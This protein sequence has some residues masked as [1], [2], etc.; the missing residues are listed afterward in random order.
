MRVRAETSYD[1][2]NPEHR[3]LLKSLWAASFPDD[4]PPSGSSVRSS[5]WR[6]L[7][8]QGDDPTRDFRST[9]LLSLDLILYLAK[10]RPLLYDKLRFRDRHGGGGQ[11]SGGPE[12]G[13]PFAAATV[14]VTAMLA[15]IMGARE[16]AGQRRRGR[17]LPL[18]AAG[19]ALAALA[20]ETEGGLGEVF[21]AAVDLL[22]RKFAETGAGHMQFPSVLKEVRR[23]VHKELSR[24]PRTT[25]DLERSLGRA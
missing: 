14:N 18:D 11:L 10:E 9:G 12:D 6:E 4:E 21:C 16:A 19:K 7:G 8:Y 1:K 2:E 17:K 23:I 22:D 5:K 24:M 15:E 20:A 25:G 13:Y 3:V